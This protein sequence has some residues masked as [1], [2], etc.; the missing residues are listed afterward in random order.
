[1][2]LVRG[3]ADKATTAGR[4]ARFLMPVGVVVVHLLLVKMRL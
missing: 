1:V 3:L 4:V 2:F